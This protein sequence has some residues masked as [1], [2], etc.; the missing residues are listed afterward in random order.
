MIPI[1]IK[2]FSEDLY[3]QINWMLHDKCTYACS[4][5][6]PLNHAGSDNWLD[7]EKVIETCKNIRAQVDPKKKMQILF[8][9]GEPTVWKNFAKLAEYLHQEKWSLNIVTN[10]S[11]SEAWW[12]DL[13]VQWDQVS[14]SLHPEFS[15]VDNFIK[16]C[17]II[18]NKSRSVYVRVMLH[19]EESLFTRAI[20]WAHKI[21]RECPEAYIE[22]IPIIYE[23]G[24]AV[25]PLSPYTAVQ[26]GIISKLKSGATVSKT[27]ELTNQKT[28]VWDT[29]KEEKLNAQLLV[30]N[31]LN[32]FKGWT[33]NAG[34]DG[35]FINSVGEIYRGTCHQ[36]GSLGNIRNG[37]VNLPTNT[38]VCEKK[39]CECITDVYYSKVKN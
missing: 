19:P 39:T 1:Q 22:W 14:V 20:S 6:P 16:K 5:C 12:E 7:L 15:D 4:Y 30:K 9:G 18:K 24:G 37:F 26:L 3:F 33:C 38:V 8:S 29:G 13:N 27:I 25:I 31:N 28:V 21:K 35:I 2:N 36:G 34:V 10:L 17:N 11:R 32:N 23:F